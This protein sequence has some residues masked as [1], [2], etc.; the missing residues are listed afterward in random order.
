MKHLKY[1]LFFIFTYPTF[2]Q[3]SVWKVSKGQNTLYLCGTIHLLR[4]SDYPLPK[5]YD[6]CFYQSQIL[7]LETD[8]GAFD[9]PDV[10]SQ[11]MKKAQYDDIRTLSTVL[12]P[13]VFTQLEAECKKLGLPLLS[14][15]KFKPSM[16]IVTMAVFKMKQ[17]G[18]TADGIDKYFYKKASNEKIKLG[19]LE[20]LDVQIKLL[21]EMGNGDENN[22][23]RYSLADFER[24]EKEMLLMI[25]DWKTGK[26]KAFL[27]QIDE[28]KQKYPAIYADLLVKR[29]QAWMPK[30]EKFLE[31][32]EVE[33]IMVG[34]M[35]L[36][37]SDGLLNQL[38]EK[39]YSVEQV[40]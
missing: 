17:L 29:N 21:T 1:I 15:N 25:N 33:C 20:T 6:S 28:M 14:L 3:T 23:I 10:V 8:I 9:N 26:N 36:Y 40:K 7:V 19:S 34:S 4:E 16:L 13:D 24:M 5:Q 31:N 2:S 12:K 22:F 18:M 38:L 27:S 35:H 37:G 11:L 39:K 32:A 30:I